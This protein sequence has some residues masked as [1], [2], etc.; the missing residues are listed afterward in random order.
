MADAQAQQPA[1]TTT[2]MEDNRPAP[3]GADARVGLAPQMDEAQSQQP[4][5]AGAAAPQDGALTQA[6]AVGAAAGKGR[7][8]GKDS[9]VAAGPSKET[10]RGR[11]WTVEETICAVLGSLRTEEDSGYGESS[12][13]QRINSYHKLYLQAAKDRQEEGRWNVTH[14]D[15]K[16][17]RFI[18]PDQSAA[19]RCKIVKYSRGFQSNVALRKNKVVEM[20]GKLYALYENEV[21]VASQESATK[22]S[23]SGTNLES[24]INKLRQLWWSSGSRVGNESQVID[25]DPPEN[26]TCIFL[27]CFLKFG[28]SA[29]GGSNETQ[30]IKT[31]PKQVD[32]KI[33][34]EEGGANRDAVR[35]D[36]KKRKAADN[37]ESAGI[38][39]D[40]SMSTSPTN[41]A[42]STSSVAS[43]INAR[44]RAEAYALELEKNERA[45]DARKVA[46]KE[47]LEFADT[48]ED[49]S[50]IR[51][52]LMQHLMLDPCSYA[53][54]GSSNDTQTPGSSR[55]HHSPAMFATPRALTAQARG[56]HASVSPLGG[57]ASDARQGELE[58]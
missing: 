23:Q 55:E 39:L 15:G 38:A 14:K 57:D 11:Q 1:P 42:A 26:W 33:R 7:G 28:P 6:P 24:K 51:R 53:P 58:K 8:K 37:M 13:E 16:A 48:D 4:L 19:E 29:L 54:Q 5:L 46:L 10:G 12:H 45:H 27:T 41:S 2:G 52:A 17:D 40:A 36:A 20:A 18:T 50:K 47:A 9:S 25:G 32:K 34:A 56:A 22:I 35:K 21:M 31:D 43:G 3:G 44:W 30:F 49:K